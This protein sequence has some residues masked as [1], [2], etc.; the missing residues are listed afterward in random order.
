MLEEIPASV[1]SLRKMAFINPSLNWRL[2]RKLAFQT[3]QR[4][5]KR[6]RRRRSRGRNLFGR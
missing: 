2:F 1:T 6:R 3:Q 4:R 5:R